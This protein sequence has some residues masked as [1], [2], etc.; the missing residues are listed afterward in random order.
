MRPLVIACTFAVALAPPLAAAELHG[1]G[2][3]CGYSP[4]IDLLPGEMITTLEDG[5]ERGSFRWQGAFGSLEV[6]GD[7]WAE[8]PKGRIVT[9]GASS[10]PT[11]FAQRRAAGGYSIAIWNGSH[12]VAVFM[13]RSP[14]TAKQIEAIGRVRLRD[15]AETS[16]VGCDLV[17]FIARG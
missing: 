9:P 5:L 7:S 4:I 17:S 14:F 3:Y 8:K 11:R 13:S 15:I 12:S 6:R 16:P 2:R 10:A 1:P